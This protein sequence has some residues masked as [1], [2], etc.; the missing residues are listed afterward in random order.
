MPSFDP[1]SYAL[2]KRALRRAIRAESLPTL[3]DLVIDVDKDWAKKNITNFGPNGID[4]H[5]MVTSHASRHVKGGADELLNLTNINNAVGFSLEAH[6]ARHE[7]GGA[8]E[9]KALG[10]ISIDEVTLASLE[11]D[12][13]LAAGKLWFRSDISE[14]RFSPDGTAV[15]KIY[16]PLDTQLFRSVTDV[17]LSFSGAN[18]WIEGDSF[19]ADLSLIAKAVRIIIRGTTTWSISARDGNYRIALYNKTDGVEVYGKDLSAPYGTDVPFDFDTGWFTPPEG[20]KDYGLR[21]RS[22]P[23][24]WTSGDKMV[25]NQVYYIFKVELK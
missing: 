6:A 8:D 9:I 10:A 20:K 13:S 18:E 14:L 7:K 24:S 23:N 19:T 3:K 2:A 4:L 25:W 17:T 11:A 1:V 21:G 22:D 16:P 15:A 12:P 5:G